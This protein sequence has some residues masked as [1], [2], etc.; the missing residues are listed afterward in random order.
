MIVACADCGKKI[1]KNRF[2]QLLRDFWAWLGRKLG[3]RNLTPEQISRLTFEQAVKGALAD[4]TAGKPISFKSLFDEVTKEKTT[5]ASHEQ[6]E[7]MQKRIS[8][9]LSKA[10]L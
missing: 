4:V 7:T 8:K 2:R 10:N 3:V 1:R 6:N 9:W 5:F